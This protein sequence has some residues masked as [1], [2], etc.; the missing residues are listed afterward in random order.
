MS[1]QDKLWFWWLRGTRGLVSLP[2]ELP[3]PSRHHEMDGLP[4]WML[5]RASAPLTR[6]AAGTLRLGSL[7]PSR[8]NLHRVDTVKDS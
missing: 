6:R 8:L 3:N 4:L 7:F 5:A 1:A 2:R